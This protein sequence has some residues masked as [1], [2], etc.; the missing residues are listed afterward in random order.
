MTSRR[1]TGGRPQGPRAELAR[2][3]PATATLL[4]AVHSVVLNLLAPQWLHLPLNAGVA[5]VLAG[6]ARRSDLGRQDLGLEARTARSGLRVGLTTAIVAVAT[7]A[8][9]ASL[10]ATRTAF[11]SGQFTARG[12]SLALWDLL[13]RIPL[14]TAAFEEFA[15]RGVLFASVARLRGLRTATVSS[16]V[17]FGC[18]HILPTLAAGGDV[19]E[20]GRAVA[21]TAA[22]GTLLVWLRLRSGSLLAPVVVHAAV[23]G[24][25]YVAA[26][27][28]T[29]A[30][31]GAG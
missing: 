24:A 21:F 20:V 3:L 16:A 31:L 17:V 15:F 10:P 30:E 6:L 23:N 27:V 25:G 1:R 11:V 5:L 14:V 2:S 8:V 13:V 4:L 7:I 18:W 22:S 9:L 26:W 29:A 12:P 28:V 19:A